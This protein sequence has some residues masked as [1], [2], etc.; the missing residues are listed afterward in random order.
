MVSNEQG[1]GEH[2]NNAQD[3]GRN[4]SRHGGKE[5]PQAVWAEV[6]LDRP[7]HHQSRYTALRRST[8]SPENAAVNRRLAPPRVVPAA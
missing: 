4:C 8:A 1:E 7:P 3:P 2:R 6:R 5:E